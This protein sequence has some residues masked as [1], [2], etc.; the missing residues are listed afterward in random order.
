MVPPRYRCLILLVALA[1]MCQSSF[2]QT[3]LGDWQSVRNLAADSN[4]SVRTKAG[5]KFHGDLVNVTT[6]ALTLDSDE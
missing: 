6:D 4:I 3:S 5:E 1:L 2:A